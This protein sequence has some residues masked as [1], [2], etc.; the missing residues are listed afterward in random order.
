VRCL[1]ESKAN[2]ML[3]SVMDKWEIIHGYRRLAEAGKAQPWEC[4]EDQWPM[5]SMGDD[6]DEPYLWCYTCNGRVVPSLVMYQRMKA[7]I[8]EAQ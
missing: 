5:V 2:D 8:D 3:S 6:D 7:T 4:P 1:T